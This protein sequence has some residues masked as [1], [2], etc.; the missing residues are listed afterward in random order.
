MGSK[1][2]YEY[3]GLPKIAIILPFGQYKMILGAYK[4][5]EDVFNQ[6]ISSFKFLK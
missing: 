6:V 3:E 1:Y 5:Y 4:D 2:E